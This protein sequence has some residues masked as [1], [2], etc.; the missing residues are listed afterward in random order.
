MNRRKSWLGRLLVSSILMI[1]VIFMPIIGKAE[2]S[3]LAELQVAFIYNFTRF[4]EWPEMALV[5]KTKFSLCVIGEDQL[6]SAIDGLLTKT[7]Y[8][9]PVEITRPITTMPSDL[10]QFIREMAPQAYP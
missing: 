4:V 1:A 9:R 3:G 6:G 7:I 5:N 2:V 8:Q 10:H